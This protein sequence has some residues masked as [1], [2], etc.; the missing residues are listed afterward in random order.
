MFWRTGAARTIR[1]TCL[2]RGHAVEPALDGAAAHRVREHRR[3][4]HADDARRRPALANRER[5]RSADQTEA[6]DGDRWKRR[7]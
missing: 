2:Q 3:A 4:V 1:S 5:D 7:V 6:D